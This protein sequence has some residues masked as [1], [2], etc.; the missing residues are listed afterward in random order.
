MPQS[1]PKTDQAAFPQQASEQKTELQLPAGSDK[2]DFLL[3]RDEVEAEFGLTRRFLELAAWRGSGPP[4]I[5]IGER[6]VR[7]RRG[8]IIAW[9]EARRDDPE[10]VK[11]RGRRHDR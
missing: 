6:A 3:S 7:Y 10:D 11:V 8:D 2:P 1:L 9:I 4:V 5:R